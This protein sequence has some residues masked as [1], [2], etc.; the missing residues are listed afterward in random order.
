M[1]NVDLGHGIHVVIGGVFPHCN[2]L[3]IQSGEVVVVDPGCSIEAL[4]SFMSMLDLELRDV[5]TVVLT[6]IHPDHI[7][8]AVRL[9]RLSKCR[10]AANK[11]TAPLFN[12]KE[13]MKRFLGFHPGQP[14]RRLWEEMV[15][16]RMH[17]ALDQGHVDEILSDGDKIALDDLTLKMVL[18]PGHT[19]DHMC[20]E[21]VEPRYLFGADI[22]CTPFG[23]FYG[24]PNSS[25]ESFK[26]T[27]HNLQETS[28][29]CLISG[30]L[31]KPAVSNY[32]S[33]LSEYSA[34]FDRREERV[35]RAVK[36]G[37]KSVDDILANPIIYPS[38]SG[39][40]MLQFERW[41]IE[42]HVKSLVQQ[43]KLIETGGGLS[44]VSS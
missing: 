11:I 20:I 12:D 29:S 27:I 43:G 22:D 9:K 7:T 24:H 38:L 18:T 42:H 21:I 1:S 25:I 33:A 41:M 23:P 2:T 5:D 16:E 34:H 35:L 13:E 17:G 15:D 36:S 32:K 40:V 6:H 28:Y 8:H 26:N 3:V 31:E 30:H 37:A 4:R 14:V 10:I 19:P 39:P 44:L